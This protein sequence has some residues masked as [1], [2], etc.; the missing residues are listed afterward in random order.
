ML[1]MLYI[2]YS[3]KKSV[4]G[5]PSVSLPCCQFQHKLCVKQSINHPTHRVYRYFIEFESLFFM[6][7]LASLV[8]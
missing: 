8:L 1:Y 5:F 3:V 7:W 6:G 4:R 2:G